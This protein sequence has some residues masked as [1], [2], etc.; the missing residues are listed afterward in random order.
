MTRA[1]FMSC[2]GLLSIALMGQAQQAPSVSLAGQVV[3]A[4]ASG[5][6]FPVT[7]ST[8][9]ARLWKIRRAELHRYKRLLYVF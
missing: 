8:I 4:A 5:Q 3:T 6:L 9:S 1:V 7:R 2:V